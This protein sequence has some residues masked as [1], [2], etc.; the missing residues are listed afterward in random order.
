M[1]V[2]ANRELSIHYQ[3]KRTTI[4]E[5]A[6]NL[7]DIASV[8]IDEMTNNSLSND[9][10]RGDRSIKVRDKNN[11]V[12]IYLNNL[13]NRFIPLQAETEKRVKEFIQS[14]LVVE[15]KLK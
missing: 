13:N 6:W 3:T 5:E 7:D 4:A 15:P 10:M 2:S 14:N 1:E 11:T 12:W 9:I 8:K